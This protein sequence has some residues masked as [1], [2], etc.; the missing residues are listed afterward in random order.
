MKAAG[1]KIVDSQS[2]QW[3]MEL[4]NKVASAMLSHIRSQG[5]VVQQR[6]HGPGSLG[7]GQGGRPGGESPSSALTTSPPSKRP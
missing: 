4:A 5:F 1:M 2:G 6:Q 3:E 7:G